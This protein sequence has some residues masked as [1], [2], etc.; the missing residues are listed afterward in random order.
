MLPLLLA[1]GV[2]HGA[3][4]PW[5]VAGVAAAVLGL[6]FGNAARTPIIAGAAVVLVA[7][8]LIGLRA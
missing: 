3:R 1:T 8:L 2:E 4:W 7:A 5:V 6:R